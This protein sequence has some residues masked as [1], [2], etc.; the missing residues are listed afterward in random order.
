MKTASPSLQTKM[1]KSKNPS[2]SDSVLSSKNVGIMAETIRQLSETMRVASMNTKQP[3]TR[4][5][6]ATARL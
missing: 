6:N 4:W 5:P 2:Q 3:S 1:E